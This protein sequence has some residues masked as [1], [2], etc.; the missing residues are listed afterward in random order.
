MGYRGETKRTIS[1][2]HEIVAPRGTGAAAP[3]LSPRV[4]A[5]SDRW[6]FIK[7]GRGIAL[8]LTDIC[9]VCFYSAQ[10]GVPGGHSLSF[11]IFYGSSC[12]A[13]PAQAW[14]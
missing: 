4:Y 10:K 2:R 6:D 14:E 9:P 8:D 5:L 12:Y 1:R 11:V 13:L 7:R 3:V